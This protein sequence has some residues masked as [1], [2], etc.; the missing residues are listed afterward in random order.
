MLLQITI[1]ALFLSLL[2]R[3][4]T[5]ARTRGTA[6]HG[7]S[8]LPSDRKIAASGKKAS[9]ANSKTAA[10]LHKVRDHEKGDLNAVADIQGGKRTIPTKTTTAKKTLTSWRVRST[11]RR[12]TTLQR[13]QRIATLKSS[14]LAKTNPPST[15][16]QRQ[17]RRSSSAR[18]LTRT[19]SLQ[20]RL[21]RPTAVNHLLRP[22][23]HAL[24]ATMRMPSV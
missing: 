24:H 8:E 20:G 15:R 17:L 12:T 10:Q 21:C 18:F 13:S 14:M 7:T 16:L 9:A 3:S 4:F 23:Y 2:I 6:A 5:M 22:E 19:T 11:T 1:S